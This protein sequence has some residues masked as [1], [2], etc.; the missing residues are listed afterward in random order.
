MN[1]RQTPKLDDMTFAIIF[2]KQ[3]P[4]VSTGAI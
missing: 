3:K 4:A 2:D 1:H